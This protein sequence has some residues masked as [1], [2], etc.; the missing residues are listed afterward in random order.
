LNYFNS[1]DSTTQGGITASMAGGS[2]LGSFFSTWCSDRKGRRDTLFVAC[3]VWIVGSTLMAAVQNVAMLIVARIVNGFA[4]GMFTSQAPIMIAEISPP[5]VRGRLLTFQ[6]WMCTWGILIMYFI[7]FGTSYINGNASFRLPWGIQM[8]PA[9]ILM[10]C[11]PFMPRSPRWLAGQDRWE[12]ATEVLA[13]LH[14]KGNKLDPLVVAELQEIRER[15]QL[16]REFGSTSW[17]ELFNQRNIIRVHCAIFTHIWSQY[18]G[19]NAMMYYIVYIFEMAGIGGNQTLIASSIQYIINTCMTLP[20]L[21][22]MDRW[23]RRQVMIWGALIL[24]TWLFIEAGL[25]AGFGHYVPDGVNGSATVTWQVTDPHASK[26]IIACSY[27]FV[28]TYASTWGPVGW[29]YPAEIIPLYI[30]SKAVSLATAFNWAMNFSL[31]FF[32]PPGF[33]NIQWR[34]HIIFATFCWTAAIH[35]FLLF[36]ESKGRT[37]EEMNDI[38]ENESIWAFKVKSTGSRLE[39]EIQRAAKNLSE[40]PDGTVE[41][42]ASPK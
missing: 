21:I 37:L 24:G 36:Q 27:L 5:H 32:C 17:L 14:A 35:V 33:K 8:I 20:A 16:E 30:R 26:A 2:L 25:M 34:V 13:D 1:P 7:T 10:C 31:T 29:L 41:E 18:S 23:P 12:E 22:F 6:N 39:G 42:V 28:A 15:I 4:V 9:I 40:N 3:C 19:M 11:V 38:F